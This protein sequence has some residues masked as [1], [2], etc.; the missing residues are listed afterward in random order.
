MSHKTEV[1]TLQAGEGK[2]K[3]I[4][5]DHAR[6]LEVTLN[7]DAKTARIEVQS[8]LQSVLQVNRAYL[9]AH[10]EQLLSDQQHEK[11]LALFERRLCGE[12]IAYLSGEREF[13]GLNF[14]VSPATLIPRA[15][16]ELLVELALQRIL[17]QG[18][19][20]VLDLGTG[21]GAIALSIAHARSNA[22]VVAVDA[23]PAALQ[24]AQQNVSELHI[25]NVQLL[26]SD[27]FAALQNECFDVIVCNPPYV[28]VDDAHLTRGDVRFEP[29][30]ALVSGPDGLDDIRHIIARAGTHLNDNS[31]LLIEH[32]H[33]QAVKVMALLQQAGFGEVFSAPDLAGIQRVS[34]GQLHSKSL[35]A[36]GV[37][38]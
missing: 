16:T 14:K 34:G 35:D 17:Q 38:N 7:V 21:S 36:A 25:N 29:R 6:L 32:G 31:W 3:D 11:Y 2:L 30:V 18:A 26:H 4:L 22:E 5:R 20:R 24:V 1:G 10:P 9:L 12:P 13:F 27:W 8:L 19:C 23:S 37:R 28:A 33:D 15:E